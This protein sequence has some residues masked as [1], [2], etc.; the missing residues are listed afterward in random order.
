MES[1]YNKFPIGLLLPARQGNTGS[2]PPLM[3]NIQFCH[4]INMINY[5]IGLYSNMLSSIANDA[6][7]QW[8]RKLHFVCKQYGLIGGGG[9]T[10]WKMGRGYVRLWRPLFHDLLIV[11]KTPIFSIFSSQ[12]LESTFTPKSQ[13]SRNFKLQSL[14]ISKE[15]S[16]ASTKWAKIQFIRL[17]FVKEFGSLGLK[18]G[19]GPFTSPSVRFFGP[20]TYTKMK[21]GCPRR[22]D[23]IYLKL[24]SSKTMPRFK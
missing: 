1:A 4:D 10:H 9:S 3:P 13:I 14:K 24:C 18:F 22:F 23:T 21:V 19:S 5:T 6:L 8:R 15:F 11:R 17:Y 16:S 2:F 12:R 20:Y 7:Q